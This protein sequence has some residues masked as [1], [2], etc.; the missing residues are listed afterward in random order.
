MKPITSL[1]LILALS[2]PGLAVA[3]ADIDPV[4]TNK[5]EELKASLGL[6][7]VTLR[8]RG[9]HGAS[10]EGTL[11]EGSMI[12][13]ELS[14][15]GRVEEIDSMTANG[16]TAKS[17]ES[18]IPAA[19]FNEPAFPENMR[20]QQIDYNE[21]IMEIDGWDS[22]GKGFEAELSYEGKLLDIDIDD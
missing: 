12:E 7:D 4:Y 10:L 14:K 22:R 8:V 6:T 1:S 2:L 13:I 20:V 3:Q 16:F 17:V 11:P 9:D 18:L 19:I 21:G 15:D 5:A